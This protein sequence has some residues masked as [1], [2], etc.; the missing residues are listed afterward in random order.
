[1]TA[2]EA[3]LFNDGVWRA[4]LEKY[5]AVTRLTVFIFDESGQVVCGPLHPT[6]FFEVFAEHGYDPGTFAECARRCL[7][8]A[9]NRPVV[10]V[11]STYSLG[12]V[13]TS[14]VLE[15]RIVGAALAGYALLDFTQRSTIERLAHE[16]GVPFLQLWEVARTNP[17]MPER[18]LQL[19]GELL[20]V[21]GDTVLRENYRTRQYEE[22]ALDLGQANSAKDEFLAVLSHELR[23]PLTPI[24]GWAR[25][26]K[27]GDSDR[28]Q[29]AAE[30]IERNALLQ[31]RMVED[32]LEITRVMRGKAPLD[33]KVL[34]LRDALHTATEPFMDSALKK[35]VSLVVIDADMPLCVRA[36]ANRLQQVFRNVISNALKFTPVGGSVTA[37]LMHDSATATVTVRDTGEGIAAEF[38]PFVFDIF[39]QQDSGTRRTHEGLG[40]G[41]ALVKRL[42][43][44]QGGEVTI[45]SE[46]AGRGTTVTIQFPLVEDATASHP[47]AP[48]APEALQELH[49]V[50]V[51][52]V[53]DGADAREFTR[54]LLETLGAD[55]MV[56]S[57]GLEALDIV[58]RGHPD[59]VLCDLWMPRMDGFGFL[60]ALHSRTNGKRPPVIALT[61][62]VSTADHMRTQA[63]GFA[64]HLDKPFDEASLLAAIGAA[65]GP[66]P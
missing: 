39:R 41:L 66:R 23:T 35:S 2:P 30:V 25:M 28:I 59:V 45:A 43:E 9:E 7:A 50:R 48:P 31:I 20:Q 65:M 6:P 22:L 15:G 63:A 16:A 64:A 12:V 8:Q 27:S 13:G 19:L 3:E 34:N 37:T 62:L 29:K 52:V 18:R 60:R 53:E 5:A 49:G 1:M 32:L 46:G 24:L 4:A 56:A 36:D 26:L 57:D 14:L 61:G 51:L 11:S 54:V 47:S 10:V 38:L 40:I 55:V 42:T 44:V 33:L 17:P 58:Y 21:L